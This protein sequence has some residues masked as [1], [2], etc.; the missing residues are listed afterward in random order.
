LGKARENPHG[1]RVFEGG[2]VGR[3][4]ILTKIK[5]LGAS[6]GGER[7]GEEGRK[8]T[9]VEGRFLTSQILMGVTQ[10]NRLEK[11]KVG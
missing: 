1:G 6:G 10:N 9:L 11:G 2:L 5:F 4:K 8:K 3:K 7:L